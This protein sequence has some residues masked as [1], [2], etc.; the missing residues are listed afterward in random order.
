[1]DEKKILELLI[2]HVN[3]K[4]NEATEIKLKAKDEEGR[5]FW[6]GYYMAC[7]EIYSMLTNI[8]V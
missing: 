3:K 5:K 2:F 6:Q 8:N 1:M 7:N 4:A